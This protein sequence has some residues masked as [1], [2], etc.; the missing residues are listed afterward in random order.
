MC[1]KFLPVCLCAVF[2]SFAAYSS[3]NMPRYA[4]DAYPCFETTSDSAVLPRKTPKMFS[5]WNG[6]EKDTPA[7][8]LEWAQSLSSPGSAKKAFDALVRRWPGSPQAPVAQ[9]RLAQ[10]CIDSEKDFEEAFVEYLYLADYYT[11]QCDYPKIIRLLYEIAQRMKKTGT[12]VLFIPFANERAVRNAFEAVVIRA[13][14]A[15]FAPQAMMEIAS[16]RE[17]EDD[18]DEAV[19]VYETLRNVYPSSSQAQDSILREA[20]LRCRILEAHSSNADRVKET[21]DF[22]KS[23]VSKLAGKPCGARLEELREKVYGEMENSAYLAAK[24]YDSVTRKKR[25]ALAA[26]EK[27][28]SEYPSGPHAVAV[29]ARLDQL[30][31][32]NKK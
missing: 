18:F 4:T 16:L 32:E 22:L 28:L 6:P 17:Q 25:N 5:W 21:Y 13:P 7:E 30:K 23:A 29:K 14:G 3:V 9:Q 10:I 27:F 2:C 11:L 15:D 26:Y 19:K 20:E 12:T 31:A 24:S 8:Q 1:D